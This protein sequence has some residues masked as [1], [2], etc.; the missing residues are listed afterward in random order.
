MAKKTKEKPAETAT[1][2]AGQGNTSSDELTILHTDDGDPYVEIDGHQKVLTKSD[3]RELE[4]IQ[5]RR[6]DMAPTK[7]EKQYLQAMYPNFDL[8][9][10]LQWD[11]QG[12]PHWTINSLGITAMTL[13]AIKR[14]Y[15]DK[16]LVVYL[17]NQLDAYAIPI[18]ANRDPMTYTY[19]NLQKYHEKEFWS[20][21]MASIEARWCTNTRSLNTNL[22][23]QNARHNL[24]DKL[25]FNPIDHAVKNAIVAYQGG[26]EKWKPEPI[27]NF[28]LQMSK[29]IQISEYEPYRIKLLTYMLDAIIVMNMRKLKDPRSTAYIRRGLQ[30]VPI[31]Y[32]A[33]G[34][35]KSTLASILGL[36]WSDTIEKIEEKNQENIFKRSQNVTLDFAELAGMKKADVDKIKDAI[37]QYKL[38][39]NPKY[40]NGL[41]TLYSTAL[42]VGTTNNISILKD[43]TGNRRFWPIHMKDYDWNKLSMEFII[44]C[45][46]GAYLKDQDKIESDDVDDLINIKEDAEDKDFKSENYSQFDLDM[47]AVKAFFK[48]MIKKSYPDDSPLAIYYGK[49]SDN[50]KIYF[51]R[52]TKIETAFAMWQTRELGRDRQVRIIDKRVYTNKV[53]DFLRD[54]I[55]YSQTTK[56]IGDDTYNVLALNL[57][58]FMAAVL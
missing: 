28:I 53:T 35:G 46:E 9:R 50:T 21:I 11:K 13:L 23:R 44:R 56:R 4:A 22:L 38:T 25:S 41:T 39:F 10:A 51:A 2:A 15:E 36:G 8:M 5:Q 20:K 12:I 34:V 45:L 52:K 3:F 42:L 30:A 57:R 19:E 27:G 54:N 26:D 32:G 40:E 14:D 31:L 47:L 49:S 29:G 6:V 1:A 48:D 18:E 58:D 16:G 33:Q 43:S 55:A 7:D 37:T 17:N 24:F